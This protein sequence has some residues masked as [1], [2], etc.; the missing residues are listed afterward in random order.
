MNAMKLADLVDTSAR[1]AATPKRTEKVT[2]LAEL[3]RRTS[4][5]EIQSVIGI[6]LGRP[7][8]GKLGV[9]WATLGAAERE[10]ASEATLDIADVDRFLDQLV[11]AQG[12]GSQQRR[13]DVVHQLFSAATQDEQQ[14]LYRMII[15]EI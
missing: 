11:A 5:D 1:V 7:Q 4:A 9:G 15:G 14:Y 13:S 10:H 8:Q 3:L 2:A 12:S 6:L